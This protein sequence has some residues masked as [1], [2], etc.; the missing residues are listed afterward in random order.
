MHF[1]FV[2]LSGGRLLYPHTQCPSHSS[3][4]L[5]EGLQAL[6]VPLL[7]QRGKLVDPLSTARVLEKVDYLLLETSQV[8]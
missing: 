5:R 7:E 4:I 3:V 1:R 8:V 2:S 6:G